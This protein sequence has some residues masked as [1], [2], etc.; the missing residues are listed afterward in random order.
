MD[1]TIPPFERITFPM[2]AGQF[3][4]QSAVGCSAFNISADSFKNHAPVGNSKI[5]STRHISDRDTTIM[6]FE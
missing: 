6:R 3:D 1:I 5:N 4:D 2:I